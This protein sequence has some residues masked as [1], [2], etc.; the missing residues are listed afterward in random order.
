MKTFIDRTLP[1]HEPWLVPHAVVPGMTGH[2]E[3]HP[4]HKKMLLV[5]PCGFP[6][7]ENFEAL[8]HT[9]KFIA[10]MENIGYI[11]EILR[12]GGEPLSNH[13]LQGLFAGYYD[14]LR[15]AGEQI[16]RAGQ[17]SAE[18][19]AGLRKDLFPG[20]KQAFYDMANAYWEQ[21][22]DRFKV[23]EE[24]R[25][26]A[27]ILAD[28]TSAKCTGLDSVPDVPGGTD[29]DEEPVDM[30]QL[31]CHETIAGMPTVFSAEAAGDLAADIQFVVSGAE[32]GAYY[33]HIEAGACSF[34]EGESASP[35]LT[36]KTPS[37]VWLSIS[38]GDPDG[39]AAFDGR[40]IHRRGRFHP[41]DEAG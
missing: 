15:Q 31:D 13:S 27:P 23:P 32:S 9:F 26:T 6:E 41:V 28:G 35:T 19:Q 8:V 21:Q 29:A 1:L 24:M 30:S 10:K 37:E 14:L 16:I 2:L 4:N 3:R 17:I 39:Q 34:H 25:H 40:E 22:M 11:G 12:P 36:I 20:G 18:T 5:S 7:F 38:R 33:L